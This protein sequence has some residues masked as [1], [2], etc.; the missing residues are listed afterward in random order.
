MKQYLGYD[1]YESTYAAAL[2]VTGDTIVEQVKNDY[3]DAG[4]V[5]FTTTWRRSSEST[6]PT[7]ELTG[8]SA[9]VSYVA[10]WYDDIGRPTATA[11]YG[12]LTSAPT[13]ED[14]APASS[15]TVLVTQTYY[16]D[17]G[18]AYKTIDPAEKEHRTTFDDAGRV[19]KTVQNYT[20]GDPATGTSDQD[21]TVETTYNPDGLVETLTAVN[22]TT[23]N[24]ITTYYYGTTLDDS[25]IA[26]A[27]LLR[28]VVYPDS[29]DSGTPPSSGPDG[30]YDRVEYKYNRQ[31]QR[32][33]MMDQNETV[34]EYSYDHLGRLT[35]DAVTELAD[36]VRHRR[37]RPTD[38]SRTYE[39]RGMIETITSY[40]AA[41]GGTALNQVEFTYN[42]LGMPEKAYQA[43]GG[44]VDGSTPYV[45]YSYDETNS[46]GQFTK[47]LR[48]LETRYPNG[49][50][51][52]Y[53]YSGTH[54]DVLNR[55]NQLRDFADGL[56]DDELVAYQYRGAAEIIAASI[57]ESS[58]WW[59]HTLD[60]FDRV[61]D[62]VWQTGV[63]LTSSAWAT[64][65]TARATA[66]GARTRWPRRRASTWTSFTPTTGQIA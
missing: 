26:R 14:S 55:A 47:G 32:T 3:D 62:H 39:V 7:G 34:H 9:R 17:D 43:H 66:S 56:Y 35:D 42:D 30:V 59:S 65:M 58:A 6:S 29:D 13:R 25:D 4:N 36:G 37:Q 5:I 31:G 45:Q 38:P 11:N 22:S 63:R 51:I 12:A 61:T 2:T 1:P 60:R 64:A 16:N 8:A 15:D 33:E 10:H 52:R 54:A 57:M 24:Q 53:A 46:A 21:V 20:D 44:E 48:L 28:A 40:D 23:G 49:R 41:E 27:D 18:E 50:Q 19:T